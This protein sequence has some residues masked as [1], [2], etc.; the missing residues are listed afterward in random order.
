MKAT[1]TTTG[2]RR[3]ACHSTTSCSAQASAYGKCIFAT[4]TDVKKKICEE[5]F[6]QFRKCVAEVVRYP[7]VD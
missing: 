4:F 2:L 6:A 7:V 5:E 3:L 1:T